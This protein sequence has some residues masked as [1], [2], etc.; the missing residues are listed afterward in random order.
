MLSQDHISLKKSCPE[1]CEKK[2]TKNYL[3]LCFLSPCLNCIP[4]C[5]PVV[6]FDPAYPLDQAY[7]QDQACPLG[8]AGLLSY[9]HEACLEPCLS[10]VHRSARRLWQSLSTGHVV[11]FPSETHLA[12]ASQGCHRLAFGSC[13]ACFLLP[14]L[15]RFL[16]GVGYWGSASAWW[17]WGWKAHPGRRVASDHPCSVFQ[18]PASLV[19]WNCC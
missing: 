17:L 15:R 6:P 2:S 19:A 11:A 5:P 10:E 14:Q 8:T 9:F 7:H 16:R 13:W 18:G 1:V 4:F 3:K 12:G